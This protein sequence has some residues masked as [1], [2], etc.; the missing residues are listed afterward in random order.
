MTDFRALCAELL[1]GIDEFT[2]CD[3]G[4]PFYQLMDRARLELDKPE[5]EG[6][7]DQE[8]ASFLVDRHRERMESESAFGCPD[9]DGAKARAARIADARAVLARWGRPAPAPK[10]IPVSERLPED[11]DCLVTSLGLRYCWWASK[12]YHSGQVRLTWQWKSIIEQQI[13]QHDFDWYFVYWLP[14]STQFLPTTVDSD[15]DVGNTME[16]C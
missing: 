11:A 7:S 8:L 12:V 2:V 13:E 1:A 15:A 9:F 3:T 10:P 5:E 16:K 6:P 14:A 4:E